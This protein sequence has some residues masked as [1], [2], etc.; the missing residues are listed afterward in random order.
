MAYLWGWPMVNMYNRRTSNTQVPEPV[1]IGG[2]VPS[3]PVNQVA[4]VSKYIDPNQRFVTCPN[5]KCNI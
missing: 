5:R 2:L 1:L 3:A 4:M